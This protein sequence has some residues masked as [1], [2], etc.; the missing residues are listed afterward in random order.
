M[1]CG[2]FGNANNADESVQQL[3][4]SVKETVEERLNAKFNTYEVV[5]YKLK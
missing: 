4:N 5:S 3:A 2:G 1:M